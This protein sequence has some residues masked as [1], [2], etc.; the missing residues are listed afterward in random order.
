MV[1]K[2]ISQL[3]ELTQPAAEDLFAIVDDSATETKK[4]TRA[5]AFK[6]LVNPTAKV[7]N[8]SLLSTDEVVSMDASGGARSFFLPAV[9]G[10]QGKSYML[11]KADSSSNIVSIVPDG[12]ETI[13][14]SA[15]Y[16]LYNQF[17]SVEVICD[18][19]GW[20]L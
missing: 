18:S 15:S 20:I 1:D 16:P 2:K 8:Y 13:N 17:E 3:T 6:R 7:A 12:S 19:V 14:G 11:R 4:I 9:S 5:N 10:L